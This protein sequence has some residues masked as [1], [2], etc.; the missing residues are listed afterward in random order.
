M[1]RL[2]MVMVLVAGMCTVGG[3]TMVAPAL[4]A[5]PGDS[6]LDC[7]CTTT[8]PYVSPAEGVAPALTQSD[9][10]PNGVF[11]VSA[12]TA[13]GST[14]L[15]VT[16]KSSGATVLR[17]TDL[18]GEEH[19]G[20]S[21]DSGRFLVWN[22]TNQLTGYRLY[23]LTGATPSTPIVDQ[24][25]LAVSG[26]QFS[27]S[28]LGTWLLVGTTQGTTADIF[29]WHARGTGA[30]AWTSSQFTLESPPG[31]AGDT[32]GA[33]AWGFSPDAAERSLV[34]ARLAQT[35]P[36]LVLV[37]LESGTMALDQ[38]QPQVTSEI[39]QFSPCGDVLGVES[40]TGATGIKVSLYSTLS[41]AQVG[42]TTV[43]GRVITMRVLHLTAGYEHVVVVDGTT[44]TIASDEAATACPGGGS[45]P[46]AA[47]GPPTG[48]HVTAAVLGAEIDWTAPAIGSDGPPISYVVT[49]RIQGTDSGSI[50]VPAPATSVIDP[51]LFAVPSSFTVT[52]NY[53][54]GAAG[55]SSPSPVV[56][57]PA[58][59]GCDSP[60]WTGGPTSGTFATTVPQGWPDL[61]FDYSVSNNTVTVTNRTT[62]SD[63]DLS[64]VYILGNGQTVDAGSAPTS[65][66]PTT[67]TLTYT[68]W[69]N[70]VLTVEVT[71][72]SMHTTVGSVLVHLTPG[73][74][75]ADDSFASAATLPSGTVTGS[76][77]G[78]TCE[79]GEP[80]LTSGGP[81]ATVWYRYQ[82]STDEVLALDGSADGVELAVY[83]G[84]SI[85]SLTAVADTLNTAGASL[86]NFQRRVALTANTTYWVQM[87]T[88]LPGESFSVSESASPPPANDNSG[89]A[90]SVYS[91]P[92]GSVDG[93]LTSATPDA[94]EP[95]GNCQ[96]A[97]CRITGS[98]WY[99]WVARS[100]QWVSFVASAGS[101]DIFRAD[102]G[103]LD[104]VDTENAVQ[105][106]P[107][108]HYYLRV[109]Q[110][111]SYQRPPGIWRGS[112]FGGPFTLQWHEAPAND[113]STHADLIHGATGSTD[114]ATTW[115]FAD[116]PDPAQQLS[117][118]GG[119]VWYSWTAPST[120]PFAFTTISSDMTRPEALV[121]S[122]SS[123]GTFT[124]LAPAITAT[125]DNSVN[126]YRVGFQAVAG[127]TYLISAD[128]VENFDHDATVDGTFTLAWGPNP[129]A[130]NGVDPGVGGQ[131]GGDSIQISGTGFSD[132]TEVDFVMDGS[133]IPA[134]GFSVLSDTQ[135]TVTTPPS[136]A[137]AA[138]V[139]VSAGGQTSAA[140]PHDRFTFRPAPV[141][142]SVSPRRLDPAGGTTVTV[143]GSGFTGAETIELDMPGS[144]MAL[145][146]PPTV[147]NDNRLTFVAP[148]E[149]ADATPIH[150]LVQT[151]A[152]TSGDS[153]ADEIVYG[154]VTLPVAPT[155]VAVAGSPTEVDLHW[156]AVDGAESYQLVRAASTGGPYALVA[157][158]TDTNFSDTGLM[159]GSTYVYAL[160]V[161]TAV[162]TS[163]LSHEAGVTTPTAPP[164]TNPP[165]SPTALTASPAVDS[166]TLSWTAPTDPGTPAL[167]SYDL[168]R[169]TTAGG[170]SDT[171]L[172]VIESS[173]TSYV[174]H[175]VIPGTTYYY[176]LSAASGGSVSGRSN[177]VHA[178]S[179]TAPH[180]TSGGTAVF[181]VGHPDSFTI[182][183]TGSPA[184][185]ISVAGNLPDGVAIHDNGDGTATLAGT[186]A[187][188]TSGTH[189]LSV[190]ATNPLGQDGATLA[191]LISAA[192][193]STTLTSS[194]T[195]PAVGDAVTFTANVAP[196][197][198]PS[199][200]P[201]PTGSVTFR[202]DGAA[203]GGPVTLVNGVASSSAISALTAGMHT[204]TAEYG[205][206][207]SYATSMG[208]LTIT[209]G[210]CR[211]GTTTGGVVVSGP[212]CFAGGTVNGP[213]TVRPGGRLALTGT[214]VHG[215][216]N[217]NRATGITICGAT[218]SGPVT[219]LD[220]SGTIT[221]GGEAGSGC[222]TDTFTGLVTVSGGG[223]VRVTGGRI[224]GAL[225]I[226][227]SGAVAIAGASV[228]GPL[229]IAANNSGVSMS[230]ASITGLV[231]FLRNIGPL[232][233]TSNTVVGPVTVADN[234][235]PSAGTISGN[236]ISGA[237]TCLTNTPPPGAQILNAV[238]GP[239]LGQCATLARK[240]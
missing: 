223:A 122:Q 239:A 49:T 235:S 8:G 181:T 188:G 79:S 136:A 132:A 39:Y 100:D 203:L 210:T 221:L 217:A 229:T 142:A 159:A 164:A 12:A 120:G 31:S 146:D 119:N 1:H 183:T 193:T 179:G 189:D 154:T 233:I 236:A 200:A 228:V 59:A 112:P 10:S 17:L 89:S 102:D 144:T 171:A 184:A 238:R 198:P 148:S 124:A 130:V 218:V 133:T 114:G 158:T 145:D 117:D 207:S 87:A 37:D 123:D 5:T 36:Q 195:N 167:T 90:A 121:Y 177:E 67:K 14:A 53:A 92:S 101:I 157:S 141:V 155:P 24:N 46:P 113:L 108:A 222:A 225:S 168:F 213:I 194:A 175:S 57:I 99:D 116:N 107:G 209:V 205:A 240:P 75:P 91:S 137:G 115:S 226:A 219:L 93:D 4:A 73:T 83:A 204:V 135:L 85:G 104:W 70:F 234:H 48:V 105:Q 21:P 106:Q 98:V 109:A 56:P 126:A 95:E 172:A 88:P 211:T 160:E 3:F 110:E 69:G 80:G 153:P 143:D 52:A 187:P 128:G 25:S 71:D 170:E 44:D 180:I 23:D 186:P 94:D 11:T 77:R 30:Q 206:D 201:V 111:Q 127:R 28:P 26:A 18:A 163:E 15:T 6:G 40:V 215:A 118:R 169:G 197:N 190:T 139:V 20:F 199:A 191:V 202:V 103:A 34:F 134:A 237:L 38:S 138:D 65:T 43:N 2:A 173:T 29:V 7:G 68:Y 220:G 149:P 19:W 216:I 131:A 82:P 78:G 50:V 35:G 41:G 196:T 176:T 45:A 32:F 33:A 166:V 151:P 212:T 182:A 64:S 97:I 63:N 54:D 208:T 60:T 230:G 58:S 161:T 152:G 22:V 66:Y 62:S 227:D 47:G 81:E 178:V 232:A 156:P 174:D 13:A 96:P 165:G 140:T 55:T 150:V 27:F 42:G 147:L 192:P 16:A 76:T 84:P 74:A 129:P 214:V 61:A 72:D 86:G 9:T 125:F 224:S 162:G 51:S 185:A 231:T